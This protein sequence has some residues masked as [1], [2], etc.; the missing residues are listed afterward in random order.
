VAKLP[1]ALR[2]GRVLQEF[3]AASGIGEGDAGDEA[4]ERLVRAQ[5]AKAAKK[6]DI[7]FVGGWGSDLAECRESPIKITARRAEAFGTDVN[8][9]QLKGKARTSG[10]CELKRARPNAG[11][12]TFDLRFPQAT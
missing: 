6:S 3:R 11:M 5:D 10:D 9:I 2:S 7:N 12:R 1:Q 8:F 4:T